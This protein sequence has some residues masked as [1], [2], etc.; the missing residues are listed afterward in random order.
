M[1]ADFVCIPQMSVRIC[2]CVNMHACMCAEDFLSVQNTMR[3]YSVG[4]ASSSCHIHASAVSELSSLRRLSI[5]IWN[6]LSS[7]C[8]RVGALSSDRLNSMLFGD[9]EDP[10]NVPLAMADAVPVTSVAA[11]VD[12]P[13]IC[14][15]PCE[16]VSPGAVIGDSMPSSKCEYIICG[17][18]T[19][20]ASR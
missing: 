19:P 8:C 14:W 20:A 3:L 6:R 16:P 7:S 9:S 11:L 15:L 1:R 10:G 17:R 5:V 4:T 12:T 18:I 2:V 13:L